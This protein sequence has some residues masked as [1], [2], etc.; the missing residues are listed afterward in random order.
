LEGFVALVECDLQRSGARSNE[1]LLKQDQAYRTGRL[2]HLKRDVF[3][4]VFDV[5]SAAEQPVVFVEPGVID[6]LQAMV[7]PKA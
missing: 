6:Q 5:A 4:R 7:A 3:A 1:G 2:V